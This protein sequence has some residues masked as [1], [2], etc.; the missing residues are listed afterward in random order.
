M[1]QSA[2]RVAEPDIEPVRVLGRGLR[3]KK[4]VRLTL[5]TVREA[6]GKTQLDVS[7]EAQMNQGDVS[8]LEARSNLGDCQV[9][10]LI[11]YIHGLGGELELIARF[12][13]KRITVVGVE[14]SV[15]AADEAERPV[16][17]KRTSARRRSTGPG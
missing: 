9:G 4:G 12:G 16:P 15:A 1:T 5:R 2:K 8:R 10:T 7:R 11:R 17:P 3:A 14:P 6:V 13:D